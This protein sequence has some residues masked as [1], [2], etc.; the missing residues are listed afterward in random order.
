M[1]F[2]VVMVQELFTLWRKKQK[3]KKKLLSKLLMVNIKYFHEFEQR[4]LW[5]EIL[6][7]VLKFSFC[8]VDASTS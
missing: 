3:K 4:K 5:Y 7:I 2:V 6:Y 8:I 1:H